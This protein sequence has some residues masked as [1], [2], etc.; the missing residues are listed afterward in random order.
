MRVSLAVGRGLRVGGGRAER[1]ED[2]EEGEEGVTTWVLAR[3]QQTP[4]L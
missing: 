2:G 3:R 4:A 1:R